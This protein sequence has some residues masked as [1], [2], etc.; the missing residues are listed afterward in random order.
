MTDA[1]EEITLTNEIIPPVCTDISITNIAQ[2]TADVLVTPTTDGTLYYSVLLESET[3]PTAAE[4]VTDGNSENVTADLPATISI[5]GLEE[6]TSYTAYLVLDDGVSVK[7]LSIVYDTDF[8]T[9]ETGFKQLNTNNIDIFPNPSKG[10]FNINVE[11]SQ[12]LNVTISDVTGKIVLQ[13]IINSTDN[14]INMNN[15]TKGIYNVQINNGNS[16]IT[17]KI[18]LN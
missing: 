11:N 7:T 14:Q 10:V 1:S 12:E 5:T 4:L 8:T 17:K 18:I 16:I 3:A 15:Q 2:T 6:N 9:I 13:K